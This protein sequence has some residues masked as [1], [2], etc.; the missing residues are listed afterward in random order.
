MFVHEDIAYAP[1]R[2][3]RERA[4]SF[5]RVFVGIFGVDRFA[6]RRTRKRVAGD[7]DVCARRLTRCISIRPSRSL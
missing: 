1:T 3:R 2:M 6:R 7:V 4:K 5:D